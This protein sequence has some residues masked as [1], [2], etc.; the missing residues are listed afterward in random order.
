MTRLTQEKEALET[1]IKDLTAKST[2]EKEALELQVKDLTAKLQ[3]NSKQSGDVK[4]KEA[5][6]TQKTEKLTALEVD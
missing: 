4:G 2:R 5:E 6:L 1:Q 3:D